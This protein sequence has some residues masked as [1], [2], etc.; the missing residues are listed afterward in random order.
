MSEQLPPWAEVSE[1]LGEL[2]ELL[3]GTEP[4]SEVLHRVAAL[5]T[6]TIGSAASCSVSVPDSDDRDGDGD[7][8]ST[9][10]AA[11]ELSRQLDEMQYSNGD[12]PCLQALRDG[13][14]VRVTA[15]TE[16]TRWGEYPQR[17]ADHGVLSMLSLPL[18]PRGKTIGALNLYAT[19][20][21]AFTDPAERA[22]CELFAGQA[23]VTLAGAQR[24][25]AQVQ[26]SHGLRGE[27]DR[28]LELDRR[29]ARAASR[30]RRRLA[31]LI[32]ALTSPLTAEQVGQVVVDA[33]GDGTDATCTALLVRGGSAAGADTVGLLA[34]RDL[35]EAARHAL[36]RPLPAG[37]LLAPGVQPGVLIAGEVADRAPRLAEVLPGCSVTVCPLGREDKTL[38]ILLTGHPVGEEPDDDA[39]GYLLTVAQLAT[40]ALE[41]A[42]LVALEQ[43][44]A[45]RLELLARASAALVS[46][47]ARNRAVPALL[48]ALVPDVA[49]WAAVHL[50]GPDGSLR[51]A[52]IGTADPQQR[53]RLRVLLQSMSDTGQ[54]SRPLGRVAR[55]QRPALYPEVT[56]ELLATLVDDPSAQTE[57]A[58]GNLTALAILPL[59]TGGDCLGTVA[60]ALAGRRLEPADVE[61]AEEVVRRAA[62]SL[63]NTRLYAQAQDAALTLQRS[64]LPAELPQIAGVQTAA[65]YL[66]GTTGLEAG[67]DFYDVIPLPDRRVGLAIGDVMGHGIAAAAVM[68]QLR[69]ALRAYALENHAPA[70]LLA[71]LNTVVHALGTGTLTTCTYAV[72]DPTSRQLQI[73]TAGHL[74]PL[75]TGPGQPTRYLDL[76]PGLPL[77]VG[78]VEFT[79]TTLTLRPLTTLLLCTDGLIERRQ[80]PLDAGLDRLA[81]II[82]AVQLP[83]EQTCQH[84]LD[85]LYPSGPDAPDADADADDD[86]ALLVATTSPAT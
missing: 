60:V 18:A 25:A 7:G 66:P 12:G 17:A 10:A 29:R 64:L 23:A 78:D 51:L 46:S 33:T 34:Q 1:G 73:A 62:V 39:A 81:R 42:R 6:R 55:Q 41:R 77:G 84:V 72:Y 65:R 74:P 40:A 63:E 52:D 59:T 71:R 54:D 5:A 24:H 2:A 67:G 75:L 38:G 22:L 19:V 79:D 50:L 44:A 80:T 45:R 68:G 14:P 37:A 26:L 31:A 8:V 16:E 4:P 70:A 9:V 85:Q 21:H 82:D 11:N 35:P 83:P 49:D 43:A 56:A 3:L 86:I 30:R 27:L 48:Q 61:L 20:P 53:G 57:L 13:V 58:A 32:E 15:M 76:D 36:D 28:L 47:V 69:A